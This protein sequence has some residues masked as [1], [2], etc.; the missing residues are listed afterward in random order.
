MEAKA[1]NAIPESVEIGE[2]LGASP[3]KVSVPPA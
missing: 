1:R 2:L 3:L